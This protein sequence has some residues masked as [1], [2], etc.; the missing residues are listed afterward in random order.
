MAWR[1][2]MRLICTR[3]L[4][5][6]L[7]WT[8]SL[9]EI[10]RIRLLPALKYAQLHYRWAFKPSSL[11][12]LFRIHKKNGHVPSEHSTSVIFFPH[13]RDVKDM[14]PCIVEWCLYDWRQNRHMQVFYEI[15]NDLLDLQHGTKHT[16]IT[17]RR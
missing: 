16:H 15:K 17:S 2:Q 10:V 14:Y 6:L 5:W 3:F 8:S 4:R 13:A 9:A 7:V 11:Y 12:P 1:Q